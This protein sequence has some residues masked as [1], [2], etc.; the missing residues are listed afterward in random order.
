MIE[1]LIFDAQKFSLNWISMLFKCNGFLSKSDEEKLPL[2]YITP[3]VLLYNNLIMC[4]L[5]NKQ[6]QM[7]FLGIQK[8][9]GSFRLDLS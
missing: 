9:E 6:Q 7:R 4:K 2:D 1:L 8:S 3:S 5:P